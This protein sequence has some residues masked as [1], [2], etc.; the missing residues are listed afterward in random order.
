MAE[1]AE[2]TELDHR[3]EIYVPTECRCGS[4]LP[5]D[6]RDEALEEVKSSMCTWFGGGSVK[7]GKKPNVRVETIGGFWAL[8]RYC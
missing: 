2:P 6:V 4:L 8:E 7:S 5:E 1:K 3:V